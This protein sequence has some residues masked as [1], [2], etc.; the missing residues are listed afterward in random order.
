MREQIY[1]F[2]KKIDQDFPTP[3]SNKVDLN[4]YA[5][6]ILSTAEILSVVK[7]DQVVACIVLYCNDFNTKYAYIPLV[8]VLQQYRGLGYAKS[9]VSAAIS[10]VKSREF[11]TIGIHTENSSALKLYQS[12][13]FDIKQ[14]GD[15]KYL[16]LDISLESKKH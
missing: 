10:I 4:E 14:Q 3:L 5:E 1:T 13:G 11:K 7:N 2:L 12:L 16:E 15:R 6:K 9:L 8:G